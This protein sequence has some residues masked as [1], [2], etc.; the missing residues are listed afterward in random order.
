MA[1]QCG[2]K[3]KDS[4]FPSRLALF[5]CRGGIRIPRNYLSIFLE[6]LGCPVASGERLSSFQRVIPSSKQYLYG[7]VCF[8]CFS[9]DCRGSLGTKIRL[10]SST[11]GEQKC[12]FCW[13]YGIQA[14]MGDFKVQGSSHCLGL[15]RVEL[16]PTQSW[17]RFSVCWENK[18]RTPSIKPRLS[19][20]A[21][22][23]GCGRVRGATDHLLFRFHDPTTGGVV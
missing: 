12:P 10:G 11:A 18:L 21:L 8:P 17:A 7:Q 23:R 3:P 1:P 19:F 13:K 14:Q 6:G 9:S 16:L 22:G 4:S 2:N 20:Q 5:P 15:L